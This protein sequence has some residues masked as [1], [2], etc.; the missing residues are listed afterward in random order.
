GRVRSPGG[1]LRP[2]VR[3]RSRRPLLAG[4]RRKGE[5]PRRRV[6][7][8]DRAHSRPPRR[9]RPRGD[10]G[11]TLRGDGRAG[12]EERRR[13]PVGPG[14]HANGEAGSSLRPRRLRLQLVS[15]PPHPGR[16]PGFL[17]QRARSPGARR[18]HRH[19][20]LG[21]HPRGARRRSRRPVVAPRPRPRPARRR[22]ARPLLALPLRRG[23]ADHGD[24]PLLRGLRRHRRAEEQPGAR[25]G[26][27]DRQP[28]RAAPD[29][30]PLGPRRRSRLRR[31]RRGTV[32]RG[33]RPPHSPGQEI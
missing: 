22:A 25:P 3:P 12:W 30:A 7:R 8:R 26:D 5:R 13:R 28:R 2:G 11:R 15:L 14:R 17:A 21:L 19:R 33:E 1:P 20:G 4:P 16:R 23:L 6:G 27:K 18:P 10:R 31:V 9:R 24:A 32:H 29:A